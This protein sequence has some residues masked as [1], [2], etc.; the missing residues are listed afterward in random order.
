LFTTSADVISAWGQPSY[1]HRRSFSALSVSAD[2][3]AASASRA[4]SRK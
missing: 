4:A 2:T 1:S 3:V